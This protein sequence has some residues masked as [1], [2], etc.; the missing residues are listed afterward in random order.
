MD[1]AVSTGGEARRRVELGD[2]LQRFASVAI[3]LILLVAASFMSESFFTVRNLFNVLRQVAGTGIIA[4]GMLYVILTAGIDL[5]VGS[6]AAL[7]SVLVAYFLGQHGQV[8]SVA[9]TLLVGAGLGA[10]SGALVAY[11]RM[12]AFVMT[13][14]MMSIAR[15]LALIVSR[16]QPIIVEND[17]ALVIVFGAGFTARVPNPVWLLLAVYVIAGVVLAFTR[18][19]RLVKAIGSNA[20]AVRLSGIRVPRHLLAVYVISGVCAAAAG[21][22]STSRSGVGSATVGVGAEL[23]AIAAVVIGGASLAGG[24]GGVINTFIGVF[25]L[26]IINNMMNLAGVPGFYQGVV[27]GGIIIVAVLLQQGTSYMQGR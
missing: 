24:R 27:M 13:L 18:F 1:A 22:I 3:L 19:G 12:P 7:A 4:V 17:P 9:L 2:V 8:Y 5:S 15:G 26:G 21:V 10:F 16:G 6:I 11:L 25:V 20:E 14:A 23:E